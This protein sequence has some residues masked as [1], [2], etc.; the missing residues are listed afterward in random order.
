[1]TSQ[2]AQYTDFSRDVLGR[3]I[4]NGLDE[5]LLST[6]QKRPD[7]TFRPDARQF[8]IVVIG[9]GAFGAAV[10][11]HAFAQDAGRSHRILVLEAGPF[12]LPEHVQ[13]LPAL[14]LNPPAPSRIADLRAIGQDKAA[15]N[16]VW[17]L[18]W[19]SPVP[20]PGL[21]YAVGGR[22]L[23][24]GGWTPQL[25]D[26]EMPQASDARHP[27]PWPS[28]TVDD[29]NNAYF[30][31]AAEQTG[32]D[33]T[34]DFINGELH[35]ALRQQLFDG[36]GTISSAIPLA[37]LPSHLALTSDSLAIDPDQLKIE[38]P[39]AVQSHT[40][41]GFFPF[42]KFSSVPLL[43]RAVREAQSESGGDDIKKRLM[44]VP[45]IHVNQLVT[46]G[47][48]VVAVQTKQGSISIPPNGVVVIAAGTIESTRL[49]LL[50]FQGL[51][52]YELIGRNLT[53]HLRSN[54]TIRIPRAAIASLDPAVQ[55]LQASALFVKGRNQG[56]HFHLQ[57]TA[58]GLSP[59]DPGTDSEAE[60][61]K[62]IP[63][64]DGFDRFRNADDDHIVLTMRGIGETE[65]QNPDTFVRLDPEPDEFGTQRA[66]VAMGDPN[67]AAERAANPKT[68][69]DFALWEAMDEAADQGA[70]VFAGNLPYEVFRFLATGQTDVLNVAAG[71]APSSVLPFS[72][73]RR[74]GMGTTHHEG[75]TLWMGDDPT[76]SVTNPNGHFHHVGNAYAAG[77]ALLPSVGSPGPMFAG[78]ALARRL[79]DHLILPRAPFVPEAGFAALFDGVGTGNWRM[80]GGG[81]FI[82]VDDVL[83]AVPGNEIG[84]Y[85]CTTPTP[86][87]FVLR[88]EW[89]RTRDDDN[90]GVFV[91]FPDPNSR[92]YENTAFVGVDFGFE[93]QI[94][95]LGRGEPPGDPIHKTGAI[96]DQRGQT[97]TQQPALPI[98]Q[99][100]LYE[101]RVQRQ[102]Y[103]VFLNGAQVTTFDFT[104]G[105]DARHPD[106][107]LPSVLGSPRFIGLQSHTGRVMFRHVR[108][109]AL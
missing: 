22:S 80:A 46:Q 71:Q 52:N 21:A 41:S 98:G 97:L 74:D 48:R 78:I 90:S 26:T 108:I 35:R 54:L 4:C 77:P 7:G 63:D 72:D 105:S 64:I 60:L 25:L 10:A 99:W 76:R 23:F 59:V 82:A 100:N 106:R 96:Y 16:E 44:V 13:N 27:N 50:A 103:S 51:P 101:I 17:G 45:N 53:A 109:K 5:A 93:V 66:F 42:N 85:W 38:A 102:N 107:G 6:Q 87:D 19:H 28:S 92:G 61:F 83:E 70:L 31:Q 37:Q 14:G 30:A 56:G 8:D 62:K 88:L 95:E 29:L 57:I 24:F 69:A 3:Y 15:R 18:P 32:A 94:D 75:G 11:Q 89:A 2:S 86:P 55:D 67:N 36:I 79:A 33:E 20:F 104:P 43:T 68:A 91:R 73:N 49:A 34:N 12:V 9:G 65:P 40:R 47:G 84:L 58:A 1:M 81:N 39:L